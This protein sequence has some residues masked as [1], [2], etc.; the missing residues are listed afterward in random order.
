MFAMKK[1]IP[2][3]LAIALSG[4]ACTAK[5]Q[6]V[7]PVK[8]VTDANVTLYRTDSLH[9]DLIAYKASTADSAQ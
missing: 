2:F 6:T 5:A 7:F 8:Y 9:A 1:F 3:I 4:L